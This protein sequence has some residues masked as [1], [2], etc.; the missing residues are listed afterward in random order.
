M[1]P[2]LTC[3][4]QELF[5]QFPWLILEVLR[6]RSIN[7]SGK[8]QDFTGSMDR[9]RRTAGM[10]WSD[11]S[12]VGRKRPDLFKASLLKIRDSRAGRLCEMDL[13]EWQPSPPPSQQ[14]AAGRIEGHHL[15]GLFV[16]DRFF[17][18]NPGGRRQGGAWSEALQSRIKGRGPLL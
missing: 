14:L 2:D 12:G 9:V 13:F 15:V 18:E 6:V 11:V 5:Q 10:L 16:A 3:T 4:P 1:V 7:D 8:C 17:I